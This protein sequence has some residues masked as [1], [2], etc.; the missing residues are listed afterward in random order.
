[1][2]TFDDGYADNYRNAVPILV[3]EKVRAAFFI[4]TAPLRARQWLWTSELRQIVRRLGGG[5]LR[6]DD[7]TKWIVP[8]DEHEKEVFLRRLT[9]WCSVLSAS[10]RESAIELM[11]CQA[12]IPRGAGLEDSFVTPG[13]LREMASAGMVIG[14]HTC[15]HPHLDWVAAA[16]VLPELENARSELE[17][18]LDR[19]VRHLGYPNP[20]GGGSIKPHVRA[21][22]SKAGY[23]TGFTSLL[24]GV[25]PDSDLLRLPRLGINA[26]D[27]E[28]EVFQMLAQ[29]SA[30]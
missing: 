13:Q 23:L 28:T 7:E 29:G 10:A 27:P 17:A 2:I 12:K 25:A 6:L 21:A 15:T 5:T 20:G 24:G 8:E 1:M 26:G 14:A 4:A 18:M 19:P 3:G 22:A 9:R 11:T 16:E 30:T